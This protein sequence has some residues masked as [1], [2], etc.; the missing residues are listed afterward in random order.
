LLP[1]T[2]TI[3]FYTGLSYSNYSKLLFANNISGDDL[4]FASSDL[5]DTWYPTV[6]AED[7]SFRDYISF[8]S[9]TN[10]SIGLE[11]VGLGHKIFD[12]GSSAL[13]R[14][15]DGGINWDT[16][17]SIPGD[18]EGV[19]LPYIIPGTSTAFIATGEEITIRRSDDYGL[20]WKQ[21]YDFGPPD[22]GPV[23]GAVGP[24]GS[25]YIGGT[26][27]RLY[28]QSDTGMYVSTDE[29]ITWNFDGGPETGGSAEP[30]RFFAANGIT[31]AP[32]YPVYVWDSGMG[33]WEEIWPTAGVAKTGT[34]PST[35]LELFPNPAENENRVEG[36]AGEGVSCAAPLHKRQSDVRYL[37]PS[38]GRL[39]HRRWH[40]RRTLREAVA[41][42]FSDLTWECFISCCVRINFDCHAS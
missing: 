26:L 15:T 13:L 42:S 32:R 2:D 29:G 25:G 22:N 40:A 11:C 6:I 20:T 23:I 38:A 10:D 4:T 36:S 17:F 19:G 33:L 5:G 1:G 30:Q 39:F 14:T 3:E 8:F 24:S 31:V 28:V 41:Y 7:N 35:G 27:S 12:P 18:S 37:V 34:V 16:I 9:A 21:I